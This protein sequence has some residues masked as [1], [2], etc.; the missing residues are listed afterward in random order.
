VSPVAEVVVLRDVLP[1]IMAGIETR[2]ESL[3]ATTAHNIEAGAKSKVPPRVDTGHM[4]N[5]IQ[6]EQEGRLTWRIV[7][8][9]EYGIY[10]ELGTYKMSAHPFMGPAAEDERPAFIAGARGLV[11]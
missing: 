3:V 6:A 4:E 11:P 5:S 2:A 8:A 10:H 7:C 9:A 1:E